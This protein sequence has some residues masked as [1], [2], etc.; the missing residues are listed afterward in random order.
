ML[1]QYFSKFRKHIVGQ[2]LRHII[3]G[4]TKDIVYA[5]W[6]AS[7]RLYRPIEQFLSEKLGRYIANTHTETNLTGSTMTN[8]YHD[9]QHVIKKHVNA[10]ENDA[11][12]CAGS[13]MTTVINKLQRMMGLRLPEQIKVATPESEK[14]VVFITH[15]EHHSNQTTWNTCDVTVVVIQRGE[16]GK[17]DQDDL[18]KQLQNYSNRPLKIGSFTACSNV[19]GI[20]TDY[21]ALA[22]I[23]HQNGGICFVD[24]AC[25]AP[26][27]D[28]DMHPEDPEQ[29]L[30]AIFFSPH[31]FLGGPATSGVL[32]FDRSLY[33]NTIPDQPG[34]GT[35][36]WTNPW[37]QQGFY[38][39]I[40]V[41]EDGGTPGFIQT[42]KVALAIKLKDEMGVPNIHE[43]E[44]ELSKILING[45]KEIQGLHILEQDITERLCIVSLYSMH[46]H[47]NLIVRLLNDRFGIQTRGGCSC[48]GTYGH[49]L[50]NVDQE[51]SSTITSKID[52]GD[53]SMK[54]GWV[55]ISLHPTSTNEEAFFIVN[56]LQQVVD[57]IET[58]SKDY[59]FDEKTADFVLRS[60]KTELMSIDD[61]NPLPSDEKV[62]DDT[63]WIT[64][65]FNRT[66]KETIKNP[67]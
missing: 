16:D 8:A 57:N 4:Q 42:I 39:D 37:G 20:K 36:T 53:L 29:K 40:E 7:G 46:I 26:Y 52:Q 63:S 56:A 27:V 14:P 41:R 35:V 55:R 44:Q 6:T 9:A 43:R 3:Q 59:K 62:N 22:K 65:L 58:W 10:N 30:D 60:S 49:I 33:Q 51:K 32:V 2:D 5:D 66:K 24:F 61:F 25:S 18:M 15:M 38:D 67:A 45:I 1:E 13:G 54:P 64:R 47:Y 50:L 34:G 11:L 28:I 17:P 48:A 12:I 19:T 23:M 31:K 21:H